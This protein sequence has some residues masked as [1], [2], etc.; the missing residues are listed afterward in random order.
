M[1]RTRS[2]LG[3]PGEFA[4]VDDV[5]LGVQVEAHGRSAGVDEPAPFDHAVFSPAQADQGGR[6][7]GIMNMHDLLR[8]RVV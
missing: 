6:L 1:G 7:I 2:S 8:A 5:S 4:S 3:E